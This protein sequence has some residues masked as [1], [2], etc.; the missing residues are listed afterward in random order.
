MGNSRIKNTLYN[1][2]WG[3]IS[4]VII[5][6]ITF[7]S[8]KVFA[9]TLGQEYLGLNG[10]FTNIISMLSLTELGLSTA[11]LFFLY[12]PVATKNKELIKTYM[13]F[14]K[15]IYVKIGISIIILGMLI[16]IF[17]GNIAESTLDINKIRMYF[18]LFVINTS[19]SYFYSYKKGILYADQKNRVT[20]IIYMIAKILVNVIQIGILIATNNYVLY[21]VVMIIGTLI[22]NLVCSRFVDKNY[23][24]LKEEAAEITKT[25]KQNIFYKVKGLIIQNVSGFVVTSS[26][27][28]II[29]TFINVTNVGIYSNYILITQTLKTLFSQ[30]YSAFTTSFGNVAVTEDRDKVFDVFKKVK[31]FTFWSVSFCTVMYIVLIQPFIVMWMGEEYLL[32]NITAIWIGISFYVTMINVPLISIQNA[33]GLHDRDQNVMIVQAVVNLIISLSLV[34]KFGVMGVV[35]GTTL[36]TIILPTISKPYIIYKE[37]FKSKVTSYYIEYAEK[38]VVMILTLV[39]I[40]TIV[41]VMFVKVTII[42]FIGIFLVTTVVFNLIYFVAYRRRYEFRYFEN[43]VKDKLNINRLDKVM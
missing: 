1:S 22:E 41:K 30:I 8:R 26:D 36:S 31:F 7:I 35:I 11:I 13:K 39:F 29:S 10:L 20:S 5:T 4:Y 18:I 9:I 32:N 33:L 40:Q 3:L 12:E 24:Y 43:L 14:Y 2:M 17:I 23:P 34:F 19:V 16:S 25:Q 28:I 42:N 21:L 6:L 37:V 38:F 15:D 27:N